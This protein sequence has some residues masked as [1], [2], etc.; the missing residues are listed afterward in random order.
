MWVQYEPTLLKLLK[1][2]KEVDLF[3]GGITSF[4]QVIKDIGFV[5]K[6]VNKR[7]FIMERTDIA[8]ARCTFLRKAKNISDW[9]KVVFLDETWLK[10][11]PTIRHNRVPKNRRAKANALLFVTQVQQVDSSQLFVGF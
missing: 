4:R 8:L 6:K 1:S 10:V 5:Y 2:L 3:K 11:G 7:K 9:S